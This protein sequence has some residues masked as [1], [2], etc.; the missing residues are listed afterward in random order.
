MNCSYYFADIEKSICTIDKKVIN[1]EI[2][3]IVKF[4]AYD[5]WWGGTVG[6]FYFFFPVLYSLS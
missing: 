3:K 1:L 6:L 2:S 5:E 4:N